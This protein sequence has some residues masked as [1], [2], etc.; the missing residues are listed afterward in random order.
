MPITE[1]MVA[2]VYEGKDPKAAVR[3]LMVRQPRQECA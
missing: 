3:E 2:V 1:I